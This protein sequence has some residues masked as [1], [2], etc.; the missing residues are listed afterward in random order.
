MANTPDKFGLKLWLAA[1]VKSKY[2][3]NAIPY[4]G[5]EMCIRHSEN[6]SKLLDATNEIIIIVIIVQ[7]TRLDYTT[8]AIKIVSC[9]IT[10]H[11]TC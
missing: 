5:K 6:M 1:G 4:L 10:M 3:L 9:L 7:C 8:S 2:L 11:G